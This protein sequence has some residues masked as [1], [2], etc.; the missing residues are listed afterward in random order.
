MSGK[1][2]VR[3]SSHESMKLNN[4]LT[5][6]HTIRERGPITRVEL[7]NQT[8]LSWGTITSTIKELL[9]AGAIR[10]IGP[11]TTEV[12]RRPVELDMNTGRNFVLGL[13]LGTNLVRSSLVDVKGNLIDELDVSVDPMGTSRQIV[14]R[15]IET[16]RR[17]LDTHSL[18]PSRLAGIGIAAPGA[19]NFRTGICHYAPRH[20]NWKDVPLKSLFEEAFGVPCV[21]DHTCNCFTLSERL[22]G[23]GRDVDNFLCILLGTG[24]GVG[25]FV[26]GE[27]YRGAESFSGQLGHICVDVN[28]PRCTCGNTGCLETYVSGSALARIAAEEVA[29]RPGDALLGAS[30]ETGGALTAETLHVA[31]S[32]GDPLS[33]DIYRRMGM[34]LG[35]GVAN[36]ISLF[37]PAR[38]IIGG[39]L[40]RARGLFL[41]TFEETVEKRAWHA[42]TR[43]IRFS[44]LERGAVMGAAALVLQEIF[45][46][47]R[48]VRGGIIS[49][50]S[51]AARRWA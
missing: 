20:P 3:I 33:I 34:Y 37:N 14:D 7:R 22:F 41:P 32:R 26:H 16:A 40:T 18:K 17:V 48:L 28:G 49:R 38:V 1:A 51:A 50:K 46:T 31:A 19:A 42:S 21:V 45:S 4:Q 43:D 39:Q 11:V 47:G 2:L 30:S 29:G 13:Q 10:E 24:L 9:R 36:L 35:V 25:I 15:L 5:V 44:V 12:G 27:V 6:L 8:R 23:Q